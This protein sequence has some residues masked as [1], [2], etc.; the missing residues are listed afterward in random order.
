MAVELDRD[1]KDLLNETT[2]QKGEGH[3]VRVQI[4]SASG[5]DQSRR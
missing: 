1:M 4:V 2:G 3:S 5:G